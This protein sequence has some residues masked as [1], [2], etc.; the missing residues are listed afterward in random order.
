MYLRLIVVMQEVRNE[1]RNFNC[2][3]WEFVHCNIKS[4]YQDWR[5]WKRKFHSENASNVFRQEIKNPTITGHL[6]LC[7]EYLVRKITR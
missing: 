4:P 1:V 5:I 2:Y 3:R 6:D 7:E